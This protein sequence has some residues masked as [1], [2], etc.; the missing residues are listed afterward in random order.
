MTATSAYDLDLPDLD[1]AG[2]DRRSGPGRHPPKPAADHWL[3]RTPLGFALTDY[4]DAVAVLRDRRFHSA[5][6]LLPQMAGSSPTAT[7]RAAAGRSC[8]WKARSTPGSAAW[9][10]RPSPRRPPTGSGRSCAKWSA[11][12]S[13]PWRPDGPLRAGGRRLRALPDPDH[14][15]APRRAQGG[16]EALLAVGHRHLPHLQPEPGR[17]PARHRARLGTSSRPTS[18]P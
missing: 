18:R 16:L 9:W 2:L 11:G 17:R 1:T 8:P 15:R 3:A 12:S 5:L 4:R 6:S 7:W 10:R 13:T 14:L